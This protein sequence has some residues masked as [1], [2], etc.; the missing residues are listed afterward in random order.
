MEGD[1]GSPALPWHPNLRRSQL[2]NGVKVVA[3]PNE[4]PKDRFYM[5]LDVNVGSTCEAEDEQ[6]IA[7]F[8]E[9]VV[10]LGTEKWQT[11]EEMRE[12]MAGLGMSFGGD[13]NASTDQKSTIY[14]M[15]APSGAEQT[16]LVTEV[17]YQVRRRAAAAPASAERAAAAAAAAAAVAPADACWCAAASGRVR[18]WRSRPC[19]PR[20]A[21]TASARRSSPRS[22]CAT[23]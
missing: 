1:S 8:L 2:D 11:P 20:S 23:R 3:L 12:L 17:L 14:T 7:H 15:E 18:R 6:G 19:Y 22:K 10:F 13:T 9:H 4:Y 5:Y 21:S 16:N